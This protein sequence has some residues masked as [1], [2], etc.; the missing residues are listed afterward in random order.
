MYNFVYF[1]ISGL[2]NAKCPWCVNGRG[3]LKSYPSRFIPPQ[4]FRNAINRLFEESL[5]DSNSLFCLYNYGEPLL[6]PSLNDILQ[7]LVDNKLRYT[8]STNASKFIELGHNLLENLQHFNISIPGFS[9]KSYNKIHGFDF[10]QILKNIDRW[11][12][13]IGHEK[14][15]VHFH[16]Y[17]FN[18]D[19]IE[20]A[21]N[22]FKQRGVK[23]FPYLAFFADYGLAMSYLNH[24]LPPKLLENASKE[25]LLF[26]V[27]DLISSS[28][29]DYTCPQRSIMTIDEYCNIL[30]CCVISKADPNYSIGSLFSLSKKEI[31]QKKFNQTICKECMNNGISYWV[32]NVNCPVFIQ[33]YDL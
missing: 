11:I 26:Y 3:N 12:N 20:V 33:K 10:E 28:P 8:L 1:E 5:I 2:C 25:L 15:Q 24:N 29:K 14:I 13:L 23:F 17:Q 22:Y 9:Q 32:H 21:S 27:D 6:H 4:E 31:E 16:V 7:I 18:L 30:T 19:E